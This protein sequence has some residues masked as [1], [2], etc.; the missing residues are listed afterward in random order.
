MAKSVSPA[1]DRR[2]QRRLQHQDLSRAQLLD[3]AERIFGQRGFHDTTLKEV[4]ERAGFSVGSVYS[5]FENKDDLFRQVFLRRGEEYMPAMRA[6]LADDGTDPLDQLHEL[7][8]FEIGYFREHPHFG[9]LYLWHA[10]PTLRAEEPDM[11]P[12]IAENFDEAMTLQSALFARGQAAGEFRPGDPVLLGRLLS[13]LI[14]AYQA[15]DPAVVGG[16]DATVERF[17]VAE[18]H[19]I[20]EA[21][22]RA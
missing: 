22:F 10:G 5:F 1:T 7:I 14:S 11:E 8:D 20:V 16:P 17:P 6:V 18:L 19:A 4:A 2:T 3:A 15:I 12:A 13:G 9:R 21:A